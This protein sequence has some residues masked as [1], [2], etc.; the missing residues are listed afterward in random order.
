MLATW[1]QALHNLTTVEREEHTFQALQNSPF[2][3][4]RQ[5][6]PRARTDTNALRLFKEG[7][8]LQSTNQKRSSCKITNNF[9][10]SN[11]SKPVLELTRICTFS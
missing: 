6:S 8:L 10:T 4:R 2:H 9:F 7:R 5:K 1:K 11:S 3:V